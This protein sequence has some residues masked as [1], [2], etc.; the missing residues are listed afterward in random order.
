MLVH[1]EYTLCNI[2]IVWQCNSIHVGTLFI[3]YRIWFWVSLANEGKNCYLRFYFSQ[4]KRQIY[5]FTNT[6]LVFWCNW[7]CI[8]LNVYIRKKFMDAELSWINQNGITAEFKD[9]IRIP[10]VCSSHIVESQNDNLVWTDNFHLW[11][12]PSWACISILDHCHSRLMP[13]RIETSHSTR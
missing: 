2:T 12:H 11:F 13:L 9:W 8:Y 6:Q 4:E 5:S 10:R 3:G 7:I 1:F